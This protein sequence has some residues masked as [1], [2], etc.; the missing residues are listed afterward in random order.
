MK[1]ILQ[2]SI[3]NFALH[4]LFKGPVNLLLISVIAYFFQKRDI[5]FHQLAA[6]TLLSLENSPLI[7][8]LKTCL[9]LDADPNAQT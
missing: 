7:H 1:L 5:S 4:I 3:L 2:A 9:I 6:G 8:L